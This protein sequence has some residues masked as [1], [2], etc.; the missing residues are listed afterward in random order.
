MRKAMGSGAQLGEEGE[1]REQEAPSAGPPV[2]AEPALAWKGR[3]GPA[4]SG[5]S[6]TLHLCS[7]HRCSVVLTMYFLSPR[8]AHRFYLLPWTSPAVAVSMTLS[9]KT[10][11]ELGF[12]EG[13]HHYVNQSDR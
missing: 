10:Q 6:A 11:G 4:V 1:L 12:K 8:D 13:G 2:G 7:A 5:L 3:Q 9:L